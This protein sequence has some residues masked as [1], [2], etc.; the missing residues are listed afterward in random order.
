MDFLYNGENNLLKTKILRMLLLLFAPVLSGVLLVL[1]FPPYDL[2]WLAWIGFVPLLT[3]ISGRSPKFGFFSSYVCGVVYFVGIFQWI[4]DVP[5]YKIVHHIILAIYLGSY[6]AFFGLALNF[7]ARRGNLLY[8][9]LAAPF[10]WIS[11]E[12]IRSNLSFLALPWPLLAHSQY[13]YAWII[14]SASVTGAYGVSFLIITFNS[15]LAII[16]LEILS[17]LRLHDLSGLSSPLRRTALWMFFLTI[18]LTALT[19]CH[20]WAAFSTANAGREVRLSLLQGNIERSRK[21]NPKYAEQIMQ[22]Y[23]EMTHEAVRENPALIVWPE[24]AT[25]RSIEIDRRINLRVRKIAETAG[26]HLLLGSTHLQ[27]IKAKGIKKKIYRNSAFLINP[28]M[29]VENQRYDKIRLL[30][31]GEY[32]PLKETVPWSFLGVPNMGGF[33]PGQEYTVFEFP[34]FRFG[35]TICWESIFPDLVREL[36][37]KGAQVMINITNEGWFGETAPYQFLASN[38]FRAVENRVY[39]VRCANTGISCFIDPYGRIVDRVRDETGRDIL[40]RGVVT[41]NVIPLNSNTIYTRYGDWFAWL[42]SFFTMGFLFVALLRK[43]SVL[44]SR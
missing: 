33:I 14:Q 40:V 25:P 35:V 9:Y 21:W 34:G 16:I 15:T 8:A 39:V 3:V 5:G 17:V 26:V 31:F 27:K 10:F 20:G 38:V 24:A 43:N 42:C 4:L 11:L 6:L 2:G 18:A 12:F 28:N 7:V 32:I 22:T 23:E 44:N 1:A 36:V 41:R 19:V 29:R 30:P 13:K 37:K